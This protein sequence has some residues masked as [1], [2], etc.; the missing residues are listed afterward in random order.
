MLGCRIGFFPDGA[1]VGL[2]SFERRGLTRHEILNEAWRAPL[3]NV[4]D[5]VKNQDLTVDMR[6]GAD[7]N[8][9]DFTLLGDRLADF[10]GNA[11]EQQ[12]VRAC[13]FQFPGALDHLFRL[14]GI[15][16]L[17]LETTDFV[18]RLWLEA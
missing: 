8:D 9:R 11:F 5:V 10:I 16:A 18:H 1:H 14:F 6:T 2:Y 4:E 3:R 15:P 7:S 17:N 13:R 12:E